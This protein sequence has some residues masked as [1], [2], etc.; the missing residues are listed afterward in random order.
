METLGTESVVVS[1]E[2]LVNLLDFRGY[3][4]IGMVA[5]YKWSIKCSVGV[6]SE[7]K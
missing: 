2:D 6:V 7:V 3:R 4:N 1:G 5:V